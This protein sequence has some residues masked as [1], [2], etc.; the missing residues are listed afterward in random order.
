MK[1]RCLLFGHMVMF[2]EF[3]S[4]VRCNWV[5]RCEL[6][7]GPIRG[8]KVRCWNMPGQRPCNARDGAE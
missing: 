8:L 7:D 2:E 1:L 5:N 4:C 6:C 3:A